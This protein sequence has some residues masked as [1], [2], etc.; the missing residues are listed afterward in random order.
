M[1]CRELYSEMKEMYAAAYR[2]YW[3]E[4]HFIYDVGSSVPA[5]SFPADREIQHIQ[6][7]SL[8]LPYLQDFYLHVIFEGGEWD[9]WLLPTDG[10]TLESSDTIAWV[11]CQGVF[12]G[13]VTKYMGAIATTRDP[14]DPR[15]GRGFIRN[16]LGDA[17]NSRDIIE[18]FQYMHQW[19]DPRDFLNRHR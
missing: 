11:W 14:L 12:K 16:M 1:V 5:R 13:A 7:F 15:V 4:N 17:S 10:K 2:A 3:S 18:K 19:V 6:E 9:S 8:S